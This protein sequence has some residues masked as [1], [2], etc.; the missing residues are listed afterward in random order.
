[1]NR[2]RV[3]VLRLE[4]ADLPDRDPCN[5]QAGPSS[6]A[7]GLLNRKPRVLVSGFLQQRPEQV[8]TESTVFKRWAHGS[9]HRIHAKDGFDS[10]RCDSGVSVFRNECDAIRGSIAVSSATFPK[11]RLIR[12]MALVRLRNYCLALYNHSIVS[13]SLFPFSFNPR[14]RTYL[15]DHFQQTT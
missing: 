9:S 7:A 10:I 3:H 5:R 8:S 15:V 1:M 12:P 2:Y 6:L 11:K 13:I 14:P 4:D